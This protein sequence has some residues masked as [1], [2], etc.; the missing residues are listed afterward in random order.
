ML[1]K[2]T[3]P[4]KPKPEP[5]PRPLKPYMTKNVATI[6]DKGRLSDEIVAMLREAAKP[7]CHVVNVVKARR[8]LARRT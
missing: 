4:L 1:V 5:A 8:K 7:I 6:V 3:Q 2:L